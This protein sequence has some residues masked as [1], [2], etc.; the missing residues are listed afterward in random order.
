MGTN[1]ALIPYYES[2]EVGDH[3]RPDTISHIGYSFTLS[4]SGVFPSNL[5]AREACWPADKNSGKAAYSDSREKKI[6]NIIS[7]YYPRAKSWSSLGWRV[8]RVNELTIIDDD[9][10][11]H[12]WPA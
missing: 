8:S 10:H 9:N 5:L 2:D 4:G 6:I 11:Y 3:I 1:D 7:A 12:T